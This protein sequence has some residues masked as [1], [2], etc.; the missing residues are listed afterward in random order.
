MENEKDRQETA[1]KSGE[2]FV[3][4]N[5]EWPAIEADPFESEEIKFVVCLDTLG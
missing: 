3:P 1:E 5:K 2:K 4:D